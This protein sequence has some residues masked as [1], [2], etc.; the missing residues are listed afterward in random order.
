MKRIFLSLA[1]FATMF[2]L[3]A[4]PGQSTVLATPT[5]QTKPQAEVQTFTG[6]ILKDGDNFV[7]SDSATK[8]KYTLDNPKKASP[9]EGKTVK[10]TG[11]LD[12]AGHLIHVETIEAVV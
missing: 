3:M 11:T 1:G 4:A 5:L 9:Y 8:T 10:V 6:T 7:L 12:T 2:G